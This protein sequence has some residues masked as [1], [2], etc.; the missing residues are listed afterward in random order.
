MPPKPS[1]FS[2]KSFKY[3]DV[4]QSQSS[5]SLCDLKVGKVR[6]D[7]CFLL[8]KMQWGQ[9]DGKDSGLMY[10]DLTF[11]QPSDC[12]LAQATITMNVHDLQDSPGRDTLTRGARPDLEITE[13]FGPRILSGEKRERQ[14]SKSFEVH[15]KIGA[16]AFSAEGIGLSARTEASYSSRWMFTGT[17][18]AIA[19]PTNYG[20]SR[21]SQYRQLVWH[22]EEND[23]EQ[24]AVHH[25]IVH[26]ALAF[27]HGCEPFYLDLQ[28]QI[29][30]RRWHRRLM[31]NLTC[32][33][34]GRKSCTRAKIEPPMTAA[35]DTRFPQLARNL[36]QAM[37]EANLHPV[38]EVPDPKPASLAH[39]A[40]GCEDDEEGT[41][42]S[43]RP[44]E[45]LIELARLLTG[46]EQH[47][48]WTETSSTTNAGQTAHSSTSTLVGSEILDEPVERTETK[49]AMTGP[50]GP[51]PLKQA[52][53]VETDT[54]LQ[55]ELA[56]LLFI[57]CQ[58][59]R[60][61]AAAIGSLILGLGK[62]QAALTG[63]G[64][65]N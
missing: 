19:D 56:C 32:P 3:V 7:C 55:D 57:V 10:L 15:P 16:A 45:P 20:T 52:R 37:T 18:F 53:Q 31:Q 36:D 2:I 63:E 8:S 60:L 47:K 17:R 6:V 12:K 33:P 58:T 14:V 26:T 34:Q 46:Q 49:D 50:S 43:C 64:K 48:L 62:I 1:I 42:T 51:L 13:F 22:L 65:L 28:I 30:M 61:L 23:L 11:H 29:K 5:A 35:A 24:Q 9:L 44:S 21:S 25:S 4:C 59:S 54:T 38:T 40:K 39:G 27:H 41:I